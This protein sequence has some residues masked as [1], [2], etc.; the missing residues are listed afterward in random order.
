MKRALTI[1]L[2]I[3]LALGLNVASASITPPTTAV[4]PSTNWQPFI[5]ADDRVS[6]ASW[7]SQAALT[8]PY[9]AC[10]LQYTSVISTANPITI[11]MQGSNNGKDWVSFTSAITSNISTALSDVYQFNTP[12]TQFVRVATTLGNSNDITLTYFMSCR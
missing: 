11:T 5:L 8:I 1:I 4:A 7:N 10:A 12:P 3:A 9:S 2:S 6:T